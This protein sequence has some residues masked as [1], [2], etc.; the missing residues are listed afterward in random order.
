HLQSDGTV[1][2]LTRVPLTVTIPP[3]QGGTQGSPTGQVRNNTTDFVLSNNNPAAFIFAGLDGTITAW[4]GGT[5]AELKATVAG[6]SYTGLAIGTSS[7][8]ANFLYAANQATGR[9]DVFD[10]NFQLVTL[11]PGG[12]FEDPNLPPG[13]PFRAFNVQNLGGILYVAYD[14]VVTV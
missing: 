3:R 2:P 7:S 10:R 8:G 4:N 13:S 12:N 11:G 9:I 5:T 14:K 6:A 1:S